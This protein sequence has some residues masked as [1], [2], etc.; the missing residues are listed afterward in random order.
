MPLR[1]ASASWADTEQK[2][3]PTAQQT[4]TASRG[5]AAAHLGSGSRRR[6]SIGRRNRISA[7]AKSR[8]RGLSRA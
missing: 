3:T 6:A 2:S 4:T 1:A 8:S 5:P 7:A